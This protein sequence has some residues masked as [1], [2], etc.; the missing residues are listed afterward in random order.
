MAVACGVG[1]TIIVTEHGD[2]WACGRNDVGQL[3]LG[4]QADQLLPAHV[5]ECE[6]FAGEPLVMMA[7]GRRHTAGVTKELGHTDREPRLWPERLGREMFGG[8]PAVMVACGGMHM[9]VLTALGL[10]WSCDEIV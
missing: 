6:V 2:A 7:T 8:S 9:L 4:S 10:V 3:G 1:F 5:G